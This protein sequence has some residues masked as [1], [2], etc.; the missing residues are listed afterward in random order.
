MPNPG[1]KGQVGV[2][3]TGGAPQGGR[4]RE[5]MPKGFQTNPPCREMCMH[6][7]GLLCLRRRWTVAEGTGC[8]H[9]AMQAVPW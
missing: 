8:L 1:R 5:D 6:Y 2:R 7:S 4:K 9:S 3:G